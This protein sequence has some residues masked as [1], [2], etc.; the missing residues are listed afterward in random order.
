MSSPYERKPGETAKAYALREITK[1]IIN[2]ELKPGALV[3]ENELAKTLGVSRTPIREALQE[4][5]KSQ[6]IEVFP[7]R[8]SYVAAISFD[9]VDEAAFLRRTLETAIVE[10]LCEIIDEKQ[11]E[12]LYEN[13]ELQEYYLSN[14]MSEKI[15]NLDNEFHKTLFIMCGKER[16]YNLMQSMMGHFDRI[17]TLS[18]YSIKDIKIVSDHRMIIEAIAAKNK[19]S[20]RMLMEKHLLRYKLDKEEVVSLYPDYFKSK[21]F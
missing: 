17:R 14:D 20:A 3:S 6:L 9:A 15:M 2:V 12:K 16:T 19:E 21:T 10:E 13:V 7:Q 1:S 5:Q 4:L 11:I 18:L 8:G